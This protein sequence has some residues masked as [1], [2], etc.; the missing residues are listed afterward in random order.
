MSSTEV[1]LRETFAP[2]SKEA[3]ELWSEEMQGS[4]VE[5]RTIVTPS[6]GAVVWDIEGEDPR[7]TIEGVVIDDYE[8]HALYIDPY[9][10]ESRPADAYWIA[11]ECQYLTARA[12]DM[13]YHEQSASQRDDKISNRQVLYVARPGQIVP[14]RVDLSGASVRPWR[15]FKQN[16]IVNRG[17]RV[18]AAIVSLALES[19]KYASGFSGSVLTPVMIGWLD[20]DAA[21][22]YTSQ[23]EQIKP[24]TR[25][26]SAPTGDA[27]NDW[28]ATSRTAETVP[29]AS[30]HV[31]TPKAGAHFDEP[32]A[33][34]DEQEKIAF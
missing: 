26:R 13:G 21:A 10:G 19:K 27:A 8:A 23:R 16:Q 3:I 7:K 32:A 9:N 24:F 15:L 1:A 18:T 6:A 31:E 34:A 11:G 30:H 20:D 22:M 4:Q 17:K 29:V 28:V 2:A 5:F 25:V 33:V 12:R 14:D